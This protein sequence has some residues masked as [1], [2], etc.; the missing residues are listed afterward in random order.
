M[1]QETSH[2]T[3]STEITLSLAL[4]LYLSQSDDLC[5]PPYSQPFLCVFQFFFSQNDTNVIRTIWTHLSG[6]GVGRFGGDFRLLCSYS[7]PPH[8]ISKLKPERESLHSPPFWWGISECCSADYTYDWH[9]K[10][11]R[12]HNL[13]YTSFFLSFL[14]MNNSKSDLTF[15]QEH[16]VKLWFFFFVR[17]LSWQELKMTVVLKKRP[18]SGLFLHH[19]FLERTEQGVLWLALT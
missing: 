1:E 7:T 18:S 16:F 15:C 17:V 19:H 8:L 10:T 5:S 6:K 13:M 11:S 2:F 3:E 12:R 14:V 9:F 4:S